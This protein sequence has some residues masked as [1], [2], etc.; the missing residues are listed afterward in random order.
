MAFDERSL[1]QREAFPG[2]VSTVVSHSWWTLAV[3]GLLG[4]AVG[5][6]ALVWPAATLAAFLTV[7]GA[8]LLVDGVFTLFAGFK[9]AKT[10][11]R[12][13]PFLFEGAL[14]IVVG[15]LAF[16]RP[17]AFALGV[18]MLV[19]VRC[20]VTGGAEIAAGNAV[21]RETGIKDWALWI[22]GGASVL[23][24]V[25][26][27]LSPGIGIATLIWL[28]GFYA[29][30]FGVALTGSAFRLRNWATHSPLGAQF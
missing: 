6:M 27:L 28:G 19:A 21:R 17:E 16:R 24:G 25:L 1:R 20:I 7:A 18:V 3:R 30:I 9:R 23:F 4:V 11:E 13:W 15:A 26:L 10:G 29:I 5:V 22:A 2:L 12:F 8:Y 14:S